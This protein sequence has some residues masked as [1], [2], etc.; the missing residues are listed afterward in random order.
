MI[1]YERPKRK[2]TRTNRKRPS[3]AKNI[4]CS[5]R[6]QPGK[7]IGKNAYVLLCYASTRSRM[8]GKDWF[9]TNDYCRF[10]N[11]R[12]NPKNMSQTAVTLAKNGYLE[13]RPIPVSELGLTH[14]GATHVYE[15]RITALG[16]HALMVLGKKMR[17][18]A[19]QLAYSRLSSSDSSI[20][21]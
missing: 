2:D 15:F 14:G 11:D 6:T 3:R 18:Q 1:T 20:E 4:P 21:D 5:P 19:N 12:M 10:Q 7:F 8:R 9:T 16:L 17:E 13:K